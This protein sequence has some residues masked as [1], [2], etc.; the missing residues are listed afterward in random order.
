MQF[1]L[2]V[3][4]LHNGCSR[5]N[6]C[7]AAIA[8][9]SQCIYLAATGH[10]TFG[11]YETEAGFLSIHSV[12]VGTSSAWHIGCTILSSHLAPDGCDCFRGDVHAISTHVCDQTFTCTIWHKAVCASMVAVTASCPQLHYQ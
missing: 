4:A 9:V 3:A 10:M 1:V 7:Q 5:R 11:S 12:L 8:D 2:T 6:G